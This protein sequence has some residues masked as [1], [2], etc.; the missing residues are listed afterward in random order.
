M[1]YN[2]FFL[3]VKKKKKEEIAFL[4]SG[5]AKVENMSFTEGKASLWM[6]CLWRN[7]TQSLQSFRTS[8]NTHTENKDNFL[9]VLQ[10]ISLFGFNQPVFW[11]WFTKRRKLWGPNYIQLA[12]EYRECP[13][14]LFRTEAFS[15]WDISEPCFSWDLKSLGQIEILTFLENFYLWKG[16]FSI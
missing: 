15:G 8:T 7:K 14:V 3:K 13:L 2:L 6:T 1:V 10:H 5:H 12:C 4:A 11:L 16:Y 9:C